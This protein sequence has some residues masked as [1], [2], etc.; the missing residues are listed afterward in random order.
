MTKFTKEFREGCELLGYDDHTLAAVLGTSVPH[1]SRWRR[2]IV[3]P[4]AAPLALR[5]LR[6]EIERVQVSINKS[7]QTGSKECKP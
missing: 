7:V 5:F 6:E 1:V 4:P 2:G 3:T